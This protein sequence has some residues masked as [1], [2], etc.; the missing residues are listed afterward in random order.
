MSSRLDPASHDGDI[1][2]DITAARSVPVIAFA[3]GLMAVLVLLVV[4]TAAMV[5]HAVAWRKVGFP[6]LASLAALLFAV[7]GIRNSMPGTPPVGTLS[8]FLVFFWAL[9]IV[10]LCMA[11]ASGSWLRANRTFTSHTSQE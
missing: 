7:P 3:L 9:L 8:D 6:T 2:L 5:A 4:V 11:T 10:S 1:R